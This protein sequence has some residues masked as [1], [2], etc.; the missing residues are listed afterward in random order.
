MAYEGWSM[1]FRVGLHTPSFFNQKIK[2]SFASE[3]NSVSLY[4]LKQNQA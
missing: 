1:G 3:L 2:L 4:W